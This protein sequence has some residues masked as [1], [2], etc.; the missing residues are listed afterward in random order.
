[1]SEF[2]QLDSRLAVPVFNQ[3]DD[4]IVY[5]NKAMAFMLVVAASRFL[6]TNN[7][8][9]TSSNLGNHATIQD[10]R[11][12]MQQLQGRQV[13]SYAG[14]GNKGNAISSGANNAGGQEKV[15]KCY[16]CQGERHMARKCTQPNRLRNTTW[17]KENI[18]LAEA[19]ESGQVLDEEQ[20]VFLAYPGITDCHDVQP[21][22]IHNAAFQT[23]DLDAYNF[24]CMISPLLKR[25]WWPISQTTIQTF[26]LRYHI[27]KLIKIK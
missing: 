4:S 18:M 7:Q 1:M 3:G 6:S 22:I 21:I 23:D 17:F 19:Q 8:L 24:D 2:P 13:Q 26:S 27:L 14:A 20:L 12:T 11:V 10:G 5:H 9:R 16:N 15:V 25:F